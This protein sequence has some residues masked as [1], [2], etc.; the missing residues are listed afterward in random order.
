MNIKL[1]NIEA[2]NFRA[3]LSDNSYK[4]REKR[5]TG[6]ANEAITRSTFY[7][8]RDDS[9]LTFP[10]YEQKIEDSCPAVRLCL[11][12][13]QIFVLTGGRS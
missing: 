1:F 11:M 2:I 3:I 9:A 8:L 6:I 10:V 5:Y 12:A 13:G 4:S 7:V